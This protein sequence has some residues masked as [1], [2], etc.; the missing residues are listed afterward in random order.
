MSKD[1]LSHDYK[2]G[3]YV[4]IASIGGA[5][6]GQGQVIKHVGSSIEDLCIDVCYLIFVFKDQQNMTLRSRW[7][8]RVSPLEQLILETQEE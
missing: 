7:I 5:H 1:K 2:P 3:D 4:N 6:W 8:S